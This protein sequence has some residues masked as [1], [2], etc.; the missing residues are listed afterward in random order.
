[1][2]L[3]GAFAASF[4]TLA[5]C[6]QQ[7]NAGPPDQDVLRV[8]RLHESGAG[9]VSFAGMTEQGSS[10][11]FSDVSF[12]T[13][14]G[15]TV[16]A[17]ATTMELKG[18]R[19]QD[20][21][22]RFDALVLEG[23]QVEGVDEV[24]GRIGRLAIENPSPAAAGAVSALLTSADSFGEAFDGVQPR[25][26]AF[27]ALE[28]AGVEL[29][30]TDPDQPGS[31]TIEVMRAEGFG[32]ERVD[33]LTLTNLNANVEADEGAVAAS[34]AS[35]RLDGLDTTLFQSLA[36][37]LDQGEEAS[38]EEIAQALLTSAVFTDVYA[39]RFDAYT[40]NDVQIDIAGARLALPSAT[41]AVREQSGRLRSEGDAQITISADAEAGAAGA[42]LAQTLALLD[43]EDVT[44]TV[45]S[46]AIADPD[47]DR[48]TTEE[49]A[50]ELE[51]GFRFDVD[52][53]FSGVQQYAEAAA[54]MALEIEDG[55]ADPA[56]VNP[57]DVLNMYAPLV[58]HGMGFRLTDDGMADRAFAATAAATGQS[59]GDIRAQASASLLFLPALAPTP[60]L[61]SLAQEAAG[62]LG[63]FINEPGV[64]AIS[65]SP[66][67]PVRIGDLIAQFETGE[68]DVDAIVAALGASVAYEAPEAEAEEEP[69]AED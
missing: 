6:G 58:V 33:R 22:P 36:D 65:V 11:V 48:I 68:A 47:Q 12:A 9:R 20:G 34:I 60:A 1:M 25:E 8:M 27:D 40:V 31:V 50:V 54:A 32:A 3:S 18:P 14:D 45:R 19:L 61:Q 51:D 55:E 35:A 52:Y 23:L 10:F 42:Q 7:E 37:A 57:A 46:A 5:A 15:A 24:D 30:A 59:E 16:A 56:A 63:A 29:S 69:A 62:A 39:K 49:Y 26:I 4:I 28:F 64:V 38:E 13:L 21:A 2:R 67:T 17:T 53:D 43:Y 44:L 66:E 41:G